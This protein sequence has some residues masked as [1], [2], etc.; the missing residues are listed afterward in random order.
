M[1]IRKAL[2]KELNEE[3]NKEFLKTGKVR[4]LN[5]WTGFTKME[6][7]S[8][9]TLNLEEPIVEIDMNLLEVDDLIT[10]I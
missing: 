8:E 2:V 1:K 9:K 10:S 6:H 5:E 7:Y 4:V 3:C